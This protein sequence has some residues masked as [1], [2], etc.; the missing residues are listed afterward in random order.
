LREYGWIEGENLH[1]ESRGAEGSAAR[2]ASLAQELVKLDVEVLV[3]F[4][5]VAG[6]A[7][8]DATTTIPIVMSVG[9]PVRLG[10]VASLSHPGGNITGY[11]TIAPELAVKRLEILHE[12]L[13]KA[14]RI[15]ELVDPSNVY[16]QL[17]RKEYETAFRSMGMQPVF[18]EIATPETLD[19]TLAELTQQRVD[20]LIVRGDPIIFSHRDQIMDFA[21]KHALPTMPKAVNSCRQQDSYLTDQSRQECL[22]RWPLSSPSFCAARSR[23]TY[24]LSNRAKSSL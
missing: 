16:F 1:I 17:V 12:L 20:A 10:W 3:T 18:I 13:P 6:R 9:D 21:L 5:A 23:A 4:G 2:A 24:R 8:K 14:T 7:A 19:Q 15:G 11:S 22:T